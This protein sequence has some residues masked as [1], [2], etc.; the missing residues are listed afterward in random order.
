MDSEGAIA[1]VHAVRMIEGR[2]AVTEAAPV[3][4][5]PKSCMPPGSGKFTLVTLEYF[6]CHGGREP[7]IAWIDTVI[8]GGVR[9]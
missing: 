8:V 9:I 3:V 6:A 7:R 4:R 1:L 5:A 2:V